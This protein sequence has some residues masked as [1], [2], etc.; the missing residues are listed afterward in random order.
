MWASGPGLLTTQQKALGG[1]LGQH[2]ALR[3]HRFPDWGVARRW[4]A[5]L[6]T[7]VGWVRGR[8]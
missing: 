5:P 8:C 6:H 7:W 2:V 3:G 4:Q 1:L